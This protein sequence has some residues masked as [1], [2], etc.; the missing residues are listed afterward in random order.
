MEE[1]E[2]KGSKESKGYSVRRKGNRK[3]RHRKLNEKIKK[4]M[5]LLSSPRRKEETEEMKGKDQKRERE[6]VCGRRDYV[7]R[8]ETID[9]GR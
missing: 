5:N 7:T 3:Q 8:K 9:I 4:R 2:M 1:S 6:I